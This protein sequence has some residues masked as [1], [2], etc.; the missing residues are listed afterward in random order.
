MEPELPRHKQIRA[1]ASGLCAEQEELAGQ[2]G[3]PNGG[4]C[5]RLPGGA[6]L[7]LADPTDAPEPCLPRGG[8]GRPPGAPGGPMP[9]PGGLNPGMPP[10]MGGPTTVQ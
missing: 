8:G 10:G 9:P 4:P 3:A 7:L 1:G 6:K 5:G 2:A